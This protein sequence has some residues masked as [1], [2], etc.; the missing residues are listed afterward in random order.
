MTRGTGMNRSSFRVVLDG[1]SRGALDL[2][3]V[4]GERLPIDL[5]AGETLQLALELDRSVIAVEGKIRARTGSTLRI[6][7]AG[8]LSEQPRRRRHTRVRVNQPT[9]VSIERDD[10]RVVTVP[11]RLVDLSLGGCSVQLDVL[12]PRDAEVEIR[13]EI[14]FTVRLGGTVIRAGG[15]AG[16]TGTIGVRF[17]NLPTD[18]QA[19]LQQ[20]L[21]DRPRYRV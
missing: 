15:G 2:R 12:V 10:G 20:F 21:M 8:E 4:T 13:A 18:T 14:P 17:K 19:T 11:A 5:R 16:S 6:S 3:C 1:E 9:T 7:I